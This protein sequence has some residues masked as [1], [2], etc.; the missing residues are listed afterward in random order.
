MATNNK[1]KSA[2]HGVVVDIPDVAAEG[3]NFKNVTDEELKNLSGIDEGRFTPIRIVV[4]LLIPGI[5]DLPE[6]SKI[7]LRVYF[8]H[9]DMKHALQ[10]KLAFL[11][12]DNRWSVFENIKRFPLP[13]NHIYAGYLLVEFVNLPF[14]EKMG[15][16]PIALGR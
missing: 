2:R 7:T 3:I 5:G 4:N 10:P 12:V 1:F 16:P 6:D 13:G 9:D 14:T 11:D 15:D 8:T